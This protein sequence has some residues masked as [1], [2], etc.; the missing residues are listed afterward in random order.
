MAITHL[1]FYRGR[2][3]LFQDKVPEQQF[4]LEPQRAIPGN[5]MD[6]IG[7]PDARNG[8]DLIAYLKDAA[9]GAPGMTFGASSKMGGRSKSTIFSGNYNECS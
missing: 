4:L 8:T 9:R 2:G 5:Q 6:F 3:G 7:L 1:I